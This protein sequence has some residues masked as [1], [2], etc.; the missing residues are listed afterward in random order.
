[1][2]RS[3]TRSGFYRFMVLLLSLAAIVFIGTEVFQVE[4]CTVVGSH[5]L[6]KDVI[7]N[8]SGVTKSDNIF[9]ID[10]KLVKSRIEGSAPF[11]RFLVLPLSYLMK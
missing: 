4:K 8:I 7:I 2:G 3:G 11:P 5:T 10:K 1:M 6:D 9:K